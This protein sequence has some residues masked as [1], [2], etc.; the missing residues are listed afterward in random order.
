MLAAMPLES[1]S[2]DQAWQ[3]VYRRSIPATEYCSL[4]AYVKN[5]QTSH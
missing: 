1:C 5:G 3:L 2:T 4:F